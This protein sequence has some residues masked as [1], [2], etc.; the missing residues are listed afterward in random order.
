MK[1][2]NLV[3]GKKY[4]IKDRD[5]VK[6]FSCNR[7]KVCTFNRDDNSDDDIPIRVLVDGSPDWCNPKDLCKIKK[8]DVMITL[9]DI[10]KG[11]I[12][13]MKSR[14]KLMALPNPPNYGQIEEQSGCNL[15]VQYI[16]D[17]EFTEE[18]VAVGRE[19]GRHIL[20]DCCHPS[21]LKIVKK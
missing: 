20:R 19:D 13:K 10:K 4:L 1:R 7:G 6:A 21:W 17:W 18:R 14:K 3:V 2:E 12:V 11:M 15:V 9:D 8:P 5:G 16:G